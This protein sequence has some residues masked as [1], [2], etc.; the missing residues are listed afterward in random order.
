MRPILILLF[1]SV[2]RPALAADG[3]QLF[4]DQCASCHVLTDASGADGP[5]L[6]GIIWRK[7]GG[8]SDFA[9]SGALK[10]LGGSWSPSRLDDFLKDTQAFAPGASMTFV[11][12][13]PGD[14]AAI[15]AYLK[16]AR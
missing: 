12:D 13:E 16:A 10:S 8:R 7:V 14:R 2:V 15:I 5:S 3:R 1:L 9:Y 4:A 11:V 6:K